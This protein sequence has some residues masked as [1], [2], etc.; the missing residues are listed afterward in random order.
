MVVDR[1]MREL[2]AA[3]ASTDDI[4]DCY[5]RAGGKTLLE[6]GI[7]LAEKEQTSLEE[8]MRVAYFE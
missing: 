6:Q 1:E 5:R 8:V 3:R 4:R 7:R 2:V